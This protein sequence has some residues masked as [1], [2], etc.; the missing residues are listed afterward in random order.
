MDHQDNFCLRDPYANLTQPLTRLHL[1]HVDIV[2][3]MDSMDSMDATGSMDS[4]EIIAF[5]DSIPCTY[6]ALIKQ[7]PCNNLIPIRPSAYATL[8]RTCVRTVLTQFHTQSLRAVRQSRKKPY[9]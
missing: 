2:N 1:I 4:M 5:M 6:K 3:S 7:S 8:T 9:A